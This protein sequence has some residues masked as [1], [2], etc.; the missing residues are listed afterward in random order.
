MRDVGSIDEEERLMG[1]CQCGGHWQLV[2]NWVGPTSGRWY[3][4]IEVQC[5]GCGAV[6][7]FEFDVSRFIEVRPQIWSRPHKMSASRY[8]LEVV[9]TAA[10][11]NGDPAAGR[12]AG[13]PVA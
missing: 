10:T 7:L 2:R 6:R 4:D 9:A 12:R 3:D 11:S 13:M 1:Q 8:R 5:Q